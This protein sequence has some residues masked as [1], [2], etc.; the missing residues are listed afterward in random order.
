VF[1]SAPEGVPPVMALSDGAHESEAIS[2]RPPASCATATLDRPGRS[3]HPSWREAAV[4]L[5]AIGA[6][7]VAIWRC[8]S[9]PH[10]K[11]RLPVPSC[12]SMAAG[13]ASF[14]IAEEWW[15]TICHWSPSLT[16]TNV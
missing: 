14:G 12:F 4:I 7:A 1:L 5:A 2:S 11:A 9:P 16:S 3:R 6:L 15:S 10:C 13:V 8:A